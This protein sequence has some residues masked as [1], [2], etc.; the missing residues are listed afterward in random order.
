MKNVALIPSWDHEI[1]N[2]WFFND[3]GADE[4]Q[5]RYCIKKYFE[6]QGLTM[7]TV[8][9][10]NIKNCD[11]FLI[12]YIGRKDLKILFQLLLHKKLHKTIYYQNEPS[13]TTPI[14]EKKK[15]KKIAKVFGK[16]L[17]WDDDL[18]DNKHFFKSYTPVILQKFTYGKAFN[19]KK[20]ITMISGANFSFDP[21]ELYSKR[22]E[23]IRYFEENYSD[24]FAFYGKRWN[25]DE[26]KSY[27]GSVENK[28]EVYKNYKFAICYENAQKMNGWVTEKIFD[29]FYSGII[30][31][32]WGPDNIEKY[33]PKKCFIDK[34]DFDSYDSLSEFLIKMTEEEYNNILNAIREYLISDQYEPFKPMSFAKGLYD[35]L[36]NI[37]EVKFS[38]I[39]AVYNFIFL[40]K[41]LNFSGGFFNYIVDYL[42]R[43]MRR[44]FNKK[45]IKI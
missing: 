34:N 33:I 18:V 44:M 14:N 22:I 16:I 11:G 2:V 8:D 37:D 20:L 29:C 31:V 1:N 26:Y 40:I 13:V 32:Y 35:N 15:L 10:V 7:N 9:L 36:E 3:Y 21:K 28:Y 25:T 41:W 42:K 5:P 19:D 4:R 43:A 27:K 39:S 38:Y 6:E 23:A 45:I 17:T 12:F 24:Q 30:P